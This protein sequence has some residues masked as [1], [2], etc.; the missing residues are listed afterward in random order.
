MIEVRGDVE[1]SAR[2]GKREETCWNVLM[3]HCSVV[4]SVVNVSASVSWNE[5]VLSKLNDRRGG[6]REVTVTLRAEVAPAAQTKS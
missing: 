3:S 6:S 2:F 5:F 1:W 4:G